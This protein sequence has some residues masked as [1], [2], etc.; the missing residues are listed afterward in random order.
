MAIVTEF[1]DLER[2]GW[3]RTVGDYYAACRPVTHR[4]ISPLLDSAHVTSSSRVLDVGTGPGDVAAEAAARGAQVIGLDFARGMI[5][6]AV[7]LHPELPFVIADAVSPPF[8]D[9]SFDAV[10]GNFTY[11]HIPNQQ[12]ALASW[13][14]LLRDGGCLALTVW[15]D[16]KA[17]RMLGLFVDAVAAAGITSTSDLAAAPAMTASDDI[18]R[19]QLHNAGFWPT[20]VT[21]IAF[22]IKP[23]SVDALWNS[24]LAATVRTSAT[25]TNKSLDVQQR[26]RAAFDLLATEYRTEDGLVVPVSVKLMAGRAS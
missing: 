16:P 13:R 15:D 1:G 10:V 24:V 3:E 14:R 25:I 2:A 17:C 21:T 23:V 19:A 5:A 9:R 20:S 6:L 4:L 7:R 11:H 8:D 18:Y 26:I 22:T 12:L